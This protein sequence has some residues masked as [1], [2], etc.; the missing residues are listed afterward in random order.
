MDNYLRFGIRILYDTGDSAKYVPDSRKAE[1]TYAQA[2]W[3]NMDQYAGHTS[4]YFHLHTN[5]DC[6][7]GAT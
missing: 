1:T 2:I 7:H 5:G 4:A 3:W 6:N